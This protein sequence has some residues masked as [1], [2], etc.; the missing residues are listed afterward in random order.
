M[1]FLTGGARSGKSSIAVRRAQAVGGPVV[2]VATGQADDGD[3]EMADRIAR[4]RAERPAGWRTVEEPTELVTALREVAG[5]GTDPCPTMV[6]DCLSLW[7]ANLMARGDDEATT[8]EQAHALGRWGAA[9]PGTVLVV[10]NEVGSGIVPM[11][12]LPRDYR[13]RLGRVNATVAG[14]ADLAQLVVA[15]RTLT[16]D[17]VEGT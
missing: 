16:L 12:P 14:Y 15:G 17:P 1:T 6:V 9:Y 4:H 2:L 5:P 7:V 13:D 11:H 10:T 8:L 3:V